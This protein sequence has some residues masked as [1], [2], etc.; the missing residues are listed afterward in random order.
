[1]L[2]SCEQVQMT[3]SA[4]ALRDRVR[5]ALIIAILWRRMAE[6]KDGMELVL[7]LMKVH[8]LPIFHSLLPVPDLGF[9]I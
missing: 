1:M 4:R 8:F 3:M 7:S 9:K 6:W 2:L 5:V